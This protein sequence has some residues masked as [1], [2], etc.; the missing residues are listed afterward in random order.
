MTKD[1]EQESFLDLVPKADSIPATGNDASGYRKKGKPHPHQHYN[2]PHAVQI[3]GAP[4]TLLDK[5]VQPIVK[6]D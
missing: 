6:G 3:S 2:G 5:E 1:A 4:Q